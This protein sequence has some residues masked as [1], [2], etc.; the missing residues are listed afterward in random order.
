MYGVE[1]L[2]ARSG[3]WG[4]GFSCAPGADLHLSGRISQKDYRG[5]CAFCRGRSEGTE[6]P[7]GGM[8]WAPSCEPGSVL[9]SLV[10]S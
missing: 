2:A 6:G 4:W 9:V 5:S 7:G 1:A 10:A 3:G 8:G